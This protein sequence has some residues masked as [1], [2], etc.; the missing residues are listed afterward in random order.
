[1]AGLLDSVLNT[2]LPALEWMVANPKGW[3]ISF[4]AGFFFCVFYSRSTRSPEYPDSSPP[5]QVAEHDAFERRA[6]SLAD[7][8]ADA[9]PATS[10]IVLVQ[11]GQP[12]AIKYNGAYRVIHP[13]R[14]GPDP[15][16][17]NILLRAWEETKDGQPTNAFR[18]YNVSK[19]EGMTIVLGR[20]PIDL[21][22]QAYAPDKTIPSPIAE[23]PRP[24]KQ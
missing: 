8:L 7:A 22:P 5:P 18:T 6:Q 24:Q 16:T 3:I 14:L 15:N 13:Y 20:A 2:L 4:F 10:L 23:R 9:D 19:I 1:M 11:R 12:F 21:P 17:G